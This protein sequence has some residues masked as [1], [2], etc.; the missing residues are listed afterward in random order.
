[1]ERVH[2]L[3][4]FRND[5]A[6]GGG[7]ALEAVHADDFDLITE[8]LAL[9]IQ[10]CSQR[11]SASSWDNVKKPGRADDVSILVVVV[12]HINDDGDMSVAPSA[13]VV[14]PAM[15]INTDD[16]D[17]VAVVLLV[18]DQVANSGYW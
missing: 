7:I 11:V 4:G 6:S 16:F 17:P 3:G 13:S 12:G 9:I 14:R 5:L 2:D 8:L 1:M 18:I 15:L 10:P